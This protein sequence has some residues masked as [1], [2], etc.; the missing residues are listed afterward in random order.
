M[1]SRELPLGLLIFR[2]GQG[3]F[4]LLWGI[5]ERVAPEQTAKIFQ[6]FCGT[7][8]PGGFAPAAPPRFRRH[9]L[10]AASSGPSRSP[11][12]SVT[13]SAG[14]GPPRPPLPKG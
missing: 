10:Y 13:G 14:A 5:D 1:R 6:F 4:R 12:E 2:V 11:L 9:L 8:L 3:G 7:A